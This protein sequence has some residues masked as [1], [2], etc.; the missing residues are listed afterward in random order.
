MS[1]SIDFNSLKFNLYEILS[2]SPTTS[3]HTI[4]K[5]F[6]NLIKNFH[7]DRN[8]KAE[9]EIYYHITTANQ[10]LANSE[11]RKKYDEYLNKS[12]N[13][14]LDLKNNFS[15]KNVSTV[16]KEDSKAHFEQ[17]IQELNK[18]HQAE[19]FESSGNILSNYNKMM[20]DRDSQIFN[21]PK[22]TISNVSDFNSKFENKKDNKLF[23]NDIITVVEDKQIACYNVN[24]NYT[25]LDVA[26][27]NLYLENEPITTN[28]FSNIEAAFKLQ[29]VNMTEN[30][31]VNIKDALSKYKTDSNYYSSSNVK[32]SQDKFNSW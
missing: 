31:N 25:N 29:S 7:P 26:F 3:E 24:D 2:V 30:E 16:S 6:R 5:A 20:Q 32:Y 1:I 12:E 21:I 15:K 13:T 18:K 17:K 11:S 27:D 10:V 23:S 22:E 8:N 14:F 19:A 28:K 4:K 9:E